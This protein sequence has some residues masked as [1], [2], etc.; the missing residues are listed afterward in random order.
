MKHKKKLPRNDKL[1][2]YWSLT[3]VTWA[4]L[5]GWIMNPFIALAIMVLWEPL[6]ILVLSPVLGK[7]GIVFGHETL[8]N[9][10]SDIFFDTVGV[11][12]GA[13]VVATLFVPPFYLF[14]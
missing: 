4:A 1:Y 3:H 6:E 7:F 8:K 9:S 5:L 13:Y 10:L 14:G 12:L 11:A 2:D